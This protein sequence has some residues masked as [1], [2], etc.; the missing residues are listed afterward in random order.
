MSD[1]ANY[2][3][4][5]AVMSALMSAYQ[6]AGRHGLATEEHASGQRAGVRAVAVRLGIYGEFCTRL[7][8]AEW[9]AVQ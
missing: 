4:L 5:D 1:A 7:E 9:E 2:P 3:N 6:N 8:E